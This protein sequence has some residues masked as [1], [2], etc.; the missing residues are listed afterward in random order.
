MSMISIAFVEAK[1]VFAVGPVVM[2][3]WAID[4]E[5]GED[6]NEGAAGGVGLAPVDPKGSAQWSSRRFPAPGPDVSVR[7]P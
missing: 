3:G 4:V 6:W 2:P 5:A 1:I 7:A